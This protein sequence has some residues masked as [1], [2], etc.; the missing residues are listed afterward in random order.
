M[1]N[2]NLV[3]TLDYFLIGIGILLLPI[4]LGLLLI[5]IS[6]FRIGSK[7]EKVIDEEQRELDEINAKIA[8]VEF[9]FRLDEVPI[10]NSIR[11]DYY[12]SDTL[13]DLK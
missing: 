3:S 11:P 5:G 10:W 4:G 1:D 7:W 2:S 9:E 12:N 6:L 13:E 8:K